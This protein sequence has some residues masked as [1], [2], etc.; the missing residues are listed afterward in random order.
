MSELDSY[1]SLYID[2]SREN[3]ETIVKNL[4]ILENSSDQDAIA[5]IFRSAH[6]LKGMSASMEFK[7]MEQL[8]HAMVDV[9]QEIRS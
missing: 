4:L 6:S 7:G 2:E 9:F 1:R 3:H 5:E 8:C